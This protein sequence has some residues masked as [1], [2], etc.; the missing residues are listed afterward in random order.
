[1]S[2]ALFPKTE[3]MVSDKK[4]RG[5][6]DVSLKKETKI[7]KTPSHLLVR[8]LLKH[9]PALM[10]VARTSENKEF[11][12]LVM[13]LEGELLSMTLS[14][15]RRKMVSLY[16]RGH[17]ITEIGRSMHVSKSYVDKVLRQ[18]SLRIL[19]NNENLLQLSLYL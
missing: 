14:K 5:R 15:R 18:I 8:R 6:E 3:D 17:T 9:Y 13:D 12:C 10:E 1:M 16:M 2:F 11:H 7:G 4:R 19:K